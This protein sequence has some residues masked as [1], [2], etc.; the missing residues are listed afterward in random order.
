VTIAAAV[1]TYNLF[2]HGRLDLFRQAVESLSEPGVVVIPVDNHS[3]DGTADV[4][5]EMGGYCSLDELTTCG[6]G[7]N[8]C[9]R[10]AIGTGAT[11]CVLSDDD[12]WWR[13]GWSDHLRAWWSEAPDDVLLTGCHLEPVFPWN[14]IHGRIVCGGIPGLIRA[15]TGAASWSFRADDWPRIGPVPER[16]Q[17]WGDVP[18]CGRVWASGARVAQVDL[19]EH[20]GHG[21]SSWG[22]RTIE[23]HGWDIEPVRRA[24]ERP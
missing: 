21:R 12:M 10:V 17:G 11:L 4:I 16:R 7:T 19:A 2:V 1:L 8:L 22:N 14:L 23:L 6:H 24:L 20:A 5:R 13:P 3:T 18:A 15:S 9:A